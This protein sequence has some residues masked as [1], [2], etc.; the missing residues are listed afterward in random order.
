MRNNTVK[1][2]LLSLVFIWIS[3]SL[4]AQSSLTVDASQLMTTFKFTDSEGNTDNSYLG[5]YTGSY[6]IGYRYLSLD[7]LIIR[8]SIGM[9]GA[10]ATMVYDDANYIWDLKYADIKAGVGYA[11]GVGRLLPYI[12]VSPY[13][14]YLLKASQTL[15]HEIFDILELESLERLDYGVVGSPG[16]QMTIS[17]FISA[18]AE[19]S[20]MMGLQNLETDLNVESNTSGQ[21]SSNVAYGITAGISFTIQ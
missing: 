19:F 16:V 6:S 14:A 18:Y 21:K 8:A 9:R 3:S 13:V 15:N 7:G 11:Y 2:I 1:T 10:G 5:K 12:T 4:A 20:Y 17:D